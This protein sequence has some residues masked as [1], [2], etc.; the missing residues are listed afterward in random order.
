ML[1]LAK[2]D[3]LTAELDLPTRQAAKTLECSLGGNTRSVSSS[4]Y[5]AVLS[6]NESRCR[7]FRSVQITFRKLMAT[8]GQ[9]SSLAHRQN[10]EVVTLGCGPWFDYEAGDR[11]QR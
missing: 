7:L 6:G 10:L 5:T 2:L 9:L 11:V 1:N 3:A 8:N 4:V